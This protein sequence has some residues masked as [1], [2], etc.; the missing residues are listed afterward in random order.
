MKTIAVLLLVGGLLIPA[1]GHGDLHEQIEELTEAIKKTPKNAELY[2]KRGELHRVHE[3]WSKALADY[4]SAEKLN[5]EGPINFL[6]GRLYYEKGDFKKAK[7]H[8][9]KF[10]VRAPSNAEAR[11]IRA[12]TLRELKNYPQALEEFNAAI[13]ISTR[14]QPEYYIERARVAVAANP[15][16]TEEAINGLEEGLKKLGPIIT[17]ELEA[18]EIETAA[19]KYDSAISRVNKIIN[20]YPRKEKWLVQRGEIELKAGRKEEARNSFKE[21]VA[22]IE[23]LSPQHRNTKAMV[24]LDKAA[25]QH[26]AK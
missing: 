20:R 1:F 16:K 2:Q 10:I 26:L 13:Q 3:N 24:S 12:R 4:N 7:Q 25:R 23:K 15:R 21:A 8:L 11:L 22:A 5:P 17:L 19:G 9:D 18:I 14:P 6:K